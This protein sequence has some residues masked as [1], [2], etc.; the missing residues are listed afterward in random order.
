MTLPP[1][2]LLGAVALLAVATLLSRANQNR[3]LLQPLLGRTFRVEVWGASLA[4]PQAVFELESAFALGAGLHL[5]L[6]PVS[7]GKA[8]RL[9]IAQPSAAIAQGDRIEIRQAA[10]VSWQ[11][12]R[13]KRDSPAAPAVVLVGSA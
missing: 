8:S 2:V 9:K 4:T 11:R 6:R 13:I 10:Y 12:A 3:K 7:G 1:L 5:T